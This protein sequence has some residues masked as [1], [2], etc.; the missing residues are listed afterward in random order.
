MLEK[1]DE[2]VGNMLERLGNLEDNHYIICITGDHTTP[3]SL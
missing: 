2:A 3:V 1:V